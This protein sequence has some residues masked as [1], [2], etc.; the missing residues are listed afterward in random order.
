MTPSG[1]SPPRI[2][3]LEDEPYW[4][5]ELQRQFLGEAVTVEAVKADELTDRDDAV[6]VAMAE[7]LLRQGARAFFATAPDAV[8][9]P[10]VAIT[11]ARTRNWEWLLR[12]LG[13]VSVVDEFCGGRRLATLC[14]RLMANRN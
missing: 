1:A 13:A 4:L 3:V 7:T 6:V 8:G 12:E 9:T 2:L 14:R 11:S 10:L 5:P